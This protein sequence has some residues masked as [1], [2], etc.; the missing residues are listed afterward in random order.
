MI[1]AAAEH[2]NV[3]VSI[4]ERPLENLTK[5]LLISTSRPIAH[6][7]LQGGAMRAVARTAPPLSLPVHLF[8]VS[9]SAA[10]TEWVD[11]QRIAISIF[12]S[13]PTGMELAVQ[14]VGEAV[15]LSG[16][17]ASIN[18]RRISSLTKLWQRLNCYSDSLNA[19]DR[20]RYC[21]EKTA[22]F[23]ALVGC[24]GHRCPVPCQFNCTPC[25]RMT[26]DQSAVDVENRFE[27]GVELADIA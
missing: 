18:S 9:G 26:Q 21:L 27:V 12:P 4:D 16:A 23:N 7:R 2:P 11:N 19:P 3:Q 8:Q 5:F 24:A 22:F 15:R 6:V 1:G 13:L 25:M 20:E 17:W 14:L 10:R